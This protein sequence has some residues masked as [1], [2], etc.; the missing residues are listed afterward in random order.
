MR[1]TAHRYSDHCSGQKGRKREFPGIQAKEN[2]QCSSYFWEERNIWF[3]DLWDLKGTGQK[4][5][6]KKVRERSAAF[7]FELPYRLINMFSVRGDTVLDPFLGTGTTTLAAM[8]S[9]RDSIGYEI[10]EN[11]SE[12]IASELFEKEDFINKVIERRLA[13]HLIFIEQRQRNQSKKPVQY[14]SSYYG[15]PVMTRQ[16]VNLRLPFIDKI[17]GSENQY[18][19]TYLE[20][21][22]LTPAQ[23]QKMPLH[24]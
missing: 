22:S 2:R 21:L 23:P 1:G 17:T 20:E 6:D 13:K 4:L 12:I 10:D 16:E 8:T 24:C 14:K 9:G 5:T 3:S 11:F 19:A 15:F 7:P 18:E